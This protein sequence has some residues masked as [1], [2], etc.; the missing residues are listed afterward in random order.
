MTDHESA[1]VVRRVSELV[2]RPVNRLWPWR[3]GQGKP[4]LLEGD[5]G[6]GKSLL[7]LDLC[8]RLSGGRRC[9]TGG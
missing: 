1:V 9:P 4:A 7:A 8:A 2:A 5:P 3:L 6:L